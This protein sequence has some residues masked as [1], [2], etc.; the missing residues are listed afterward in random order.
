MVRRVRAYS[1]VA[2]VAVCLA[3]SLISFCCIL[4]HHKC[5]NNMCELCLQISLTYTLMQSV[6]LASAFSGAALL[7][8]RGVHIFTDNTS[9]AP[10]TPL[11]MKVRL[12]N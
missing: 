12:L 2:A 7:Y 1:I 10:Y 4:L 9:K 8:I 6:T 3:I 5:D 11:D